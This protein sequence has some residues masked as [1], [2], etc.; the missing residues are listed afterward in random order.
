MANRKDL[1]ILIV[2]ATQHIQRMKKSAEGKSEAMKSA[3]QQ[4]AEAVERA[5]EWINERMPDE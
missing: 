5:I 4:Q 2:A 1:N 3:V